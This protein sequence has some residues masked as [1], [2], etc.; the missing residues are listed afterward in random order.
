MQ[1][2]IIN[3]R[4]IERD[5]SEINPKDLDL[6]IDTDQDHGRG[7]DHTLEIADDLIQGIT[8]RATIKRKE[9]HPEDK[10]ALMIEGLVCIINLVI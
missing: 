3:H 10:Q 9:D 5:H 2:I 8:K 4:G 7:E 6:K 1:A